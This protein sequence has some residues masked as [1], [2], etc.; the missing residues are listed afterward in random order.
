TATEHEL[1]FEERRQA[2]A[3]LLFN[4]S[5]NFDD[6]RRTLAVVGLRAYTHEVDSQATDLRNMA[7]Q[8]QHAMETDLAAFEVEHKDLV[9]QIVI[10]A[11]RVRHQDEKLNKQTLLAQLHATLLEL[12]KTDVKRVS[13]EIDEAKKATDIALKGQSRLEDALFQ[14]HR[15]MAA[16][17]EQNQQLLRQINALELGR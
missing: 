14:A 2:I 6:H 10:A 1:A 8:I 9:R 16:A 13:A 11:E 12:R 15:A 17:G 7:P 5:D 4:L 3:H